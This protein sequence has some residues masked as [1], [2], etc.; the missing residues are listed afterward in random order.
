MLPLDRKLAIDQL[1]RKLQ[2]L[3]V[4][5][6]FD[7]PPKGWIYAI[8]TALNMSLTQLARRIN[9]TVPSTREIEEREEHKNITIKKLMEVGESL[10]LRFVYGFIPKEQTIK[11][12]IEKRALEV[13]EDL[14]MRTS[15]SMKL[16]EQ[17]NSPERIA[18]AIKDRAESLQIEMPKFL[19][20]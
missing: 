19:W 8:R 10:D 11:K 2:K 12:M 14:V 20:D 7:V 13:A 17:E 16:E 5:N 9:K 4:L 18:Q 1:D 15:H 3:A 6:D